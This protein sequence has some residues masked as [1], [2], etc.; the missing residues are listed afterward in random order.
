MSEHDKASDLLAR[1][2]LFGSLPA[3]LRML[4][5]SRMR[6]VAFTAGQHVFARGDE[7][8]ELYLVR[9]G[10]VRLSIITPEGRELSL[11]HATAGG[12]FGEIAVLDGGSRTADAT[13]ISRVSALS[14]SR[15]AFS[16]MMAASPAIAQSAIAFLCRRLRETDVKI[17][18]IALHSIE[19]RLARFFLSA[20]RL[21]NA[22]A[23]GES[24]PLKLDMSQSE[25]ALLL[26][27][28]R[29]K[30][31]TALSALEAAGAL[32][33]EGAIIHCDLDQLESMSAS[34]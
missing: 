8:R 21:Q 20:A 5:A 26:G 14:L 24:W 11:A 28:S 31:N 16:E 6:P 32:R 19:V 33:R 27:A 2:D 13:A 3:D 9:S 29:P 23:R 1:T 7:A 12:V 34:D 18:A 22:G 15:A 30:V 10:R 17:E 25:L 4:V